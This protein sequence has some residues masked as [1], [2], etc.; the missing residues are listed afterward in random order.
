MTSR[1]ELHELVD[2]LPEGE[3][4]SAQRILRALPDDPVVRAL[5]TAPIDDEPVTD[6][7]RGLLDKARESMRSDGGIGTAELL[8]NLGL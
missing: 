1:A 8:Q 3:L 5:L 4:E 6:D 2:M 7:E